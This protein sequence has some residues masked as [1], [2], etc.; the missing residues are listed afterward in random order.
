MQHRF[1]IACIVSVATAIN[2]AAQQTCDLKHRLSGVENHEWT[3]YANPALMATRHKTSFSDAAATFTHSSGDK[4]VVAQTGRAAN[5]AGFAASSYQ[6]MGKGSAVWGKAAYHRR[7]TKNV[8]WNETS[9]FL[10]VYPYVIA[11]TVGGKMQRESYLFSIGY[12]QSRK[13]WSYGVEAEYQSAVEYRDIDPRPKNNTIYAIFKAGASARVNDRYQAG[14]YVGWRHYSQQQNITFMNPYGNIMLYQMSGLAM[15]YHRF[16]GTLGDANYTGDTW[17]GGLTLHPLQGKGIEAQL[18][19]GHRNMQK[20]LSGLNNAPINDIAEWTYGGE[21]AVR[22]TNGYARL[23]ISYDD[24]RGT[25]RVYDDGVH[26]YNQISSSQPFHATTL[27]GTAEAA[28]QWTTGN[29]KLTIEPTAAITITSHKQTY[30]SPKR[31]LNFTNLSPQVGLLGLLQ[32]GR[33][34]LTVRFSETRQQNIC[35][36]LDINEPELFDKPLQTVYSNYTMLTAGAWT[37]QASARYDIGMSGVVSTLYIRI[38]AQYTTLSGNHHRQGID[39]S[40][41]VTL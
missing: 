7:L 34:L 36:K 6:R 24:R 4:A 39:V 35:R 21:A 9:D 13:L 29:G 25:E 22:R 33:N 32:T 5:D 37:T 31:Q 17:F 10:E 3:T 20:Q 26:N 23:Q 40:L 38:N 12:A 18:N 30:A 41:G 2:A 15:Q 11:D 16:A 19:I 28:R 1:I 14:A 27:H 8:E